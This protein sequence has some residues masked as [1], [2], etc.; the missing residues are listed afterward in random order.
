MLLQ[1]FNVSKV[2]GA[3]IILWGV[4]TSCTAAVRTSPQMIALRTL[5]GCLE[6]VITPALIM[7]TSAWYQ[8]DEAAPR[9]GFW[10]SGLGAGQIIGGLISYGAQ[11]SHNTHFQGWRVMF[12][13][14]GIFN[15]LVGATIYFWLPPTPETAKFLNYGEKEVIA[16]RLAEDHAGIGLKVLRVRSVLETFL[17]LQT[18]LL[19][20][21]TILN[22]IPSG[23][24]TTYSSILIKNF[25]Y[26]PKQAALLNMPSGI[27]SICALMGSTWIITKGYQR[28]VSIVVALCVTLLGACLMSFSPK[29]NKAALLTGMYLVNAVISP[30]YMQISWF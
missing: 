8:K 26:S 29:S 28:W 21:L 17:D 2:L 23:V 25:G 18:W 4:V 20:L 27:V 13:C 24:I 9:F 11:S 10:Y 22:V 15:V 7:L 5:L 12:L 3:N 14:I 16:Q 1:R 30:A 19:C 6:A